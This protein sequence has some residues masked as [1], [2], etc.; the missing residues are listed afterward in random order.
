MNEEVAGEMNEEVAGQT[1]EEMNEEVAGKMN[2]EMNEEVAG[3]MNKCTFVISARIQKRRR[4]RNGGRE[5]SVTE[6]RLEGRKNGE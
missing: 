3:K 4:Q 1:N 2:V 5:G 6:G